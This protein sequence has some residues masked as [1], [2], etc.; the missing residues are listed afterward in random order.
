MKQILI[1]ED[2]SFLN[3]MLSYNL[4]ADG[5]EITSV[6]NA[7]TAA[8]A[9]SSRE[10]DLV[11]LD[12]NLPDGNGYDLCKLIKPE[13]PDTIV[14]FLTANDQES[15]GRS[16]LL[17]LRLAFSYG[18]I[19]RISKPVLA[20][21]EAILLPPCQSDARSP[22][23]QPIQRFNRVACRYL[24]R[25]L[26]ASCFRRIRT[27]QSGQYLA[28]LDFGVNAAPHTA[29]RFTLSRLWMISAYSDPSSGRT[30]ARNHRHS[31]E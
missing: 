28:R 6:L 25:C 8:Q 23:W 16:A 5:Y 21:I 11:L 9:L 17:A 29:H 1:V 22:L 31:N 14:I 15:A 12:I 18:F 26:S 4:T 2:D 30:A 19:L 3:K 20:G 27:A 10:F 13:Y 7:R 24:F